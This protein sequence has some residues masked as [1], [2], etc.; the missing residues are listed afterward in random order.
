MITPPFYD[1]IA[2]FAVKHQIRRLLFEEGWFSLLGWHPAF[3][4]GFDSERQI[5]SSMTL[6]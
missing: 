4:M 2:G 1:E 6:E 5:V 3:R